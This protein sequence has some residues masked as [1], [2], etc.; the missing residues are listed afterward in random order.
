MADSSNISIGIG[1]DTSKLRGD[2]AVA[3][4]EV[5]QFGAELRAAA[6]ESLETGDR[7]KLDELAAKYD[8][9]AKKVTDLKGALSSTSAEVKDHHGHLATLSAQLATAQ[10]GM[11]ALHQR[12]GELGATM[13]RI[14]TSIFPGFKEIFVA[15]G[16]ITTVG[17]I[18]E[19]V[20]GAAEWGHNIRA[21]AQELGVSERQ[22]LSW[23]KAA[24]LAG[25]DTDNL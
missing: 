12:V 2:L 6:K 10:Q 7:S 22:L 19:L 8:A 23:S 15:F 16:A 25:A 13:Q 1:A 21:T 4:A 5:R 9:S 18:Y 11:S 3:Q 17:G 20:R 14:S 24:K